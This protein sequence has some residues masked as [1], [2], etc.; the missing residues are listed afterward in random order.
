VYKRQTILEERQNEITAAKLDRWIGRHVEVLIEEPIQGSAMALGR[1]F[2]QAQEVDGL[3]VVHGENLT[4]GQV[5]KTQIVKRNGVD[6]EAR[7]QK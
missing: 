2:M 1:S 5:V 7:I 3:I 4:S 6:L